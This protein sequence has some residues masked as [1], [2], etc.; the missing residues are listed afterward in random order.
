MNYNFNNVNIK[1]IQIDIKF[2]PNKIM[3]HA[4]DLSKEERN[5]IIK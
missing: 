3:E 4:S 5:K 1:E 2:K